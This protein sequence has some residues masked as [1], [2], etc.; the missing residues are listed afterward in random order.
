MSTPFLMKRMMTQICWRGHQAKV[1]GKPTFHVIVL[2]LIQTSTQSGF[3]LNFCWFMSF[4]SICM[5]LQT[6]F[7]LLCWLG[8]E[9]F[10]QRLAK[11]LK[12]GWK[13]TVVNPGSS[14]TST[15]VYYDLKKTCQK[16]L[17]GCENSLYL[18]IYVFACHWARTIILILS[19]KL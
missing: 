13:K 5:D 15:L 10:F 6:Y 11:L 19:T 8:L 7:Y 14:F 18:Y 4:V 3:L 16:L 1:Q 2:F 17:N 9:I 12:F